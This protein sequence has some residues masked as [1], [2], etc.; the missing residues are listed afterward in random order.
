MMVYELLT[1][2]TYLSGNDAMEL[3][4]QLLFSEIEAPSKRTK[5]LPAAFDAWF[6]KAC[7]RDPSKR[8][9]TTSAQ[10]TALTVALGI[11]APPASA[12][13]ALADAI[14][15]ITPPTTVSYGFTTSP[16]RPASPEQ[17]NAALASTQPAPSAKEPSDQPRSALEPRRAYASAPDTIPEGQLTPNA[18]ATPASRHPGI[19]DAAKPPVQRAIVAVA[20][21]TLLTLTTG[22]L[23]FRACSSAGRPASAPVDRPPK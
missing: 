21:A 3:I 17:L 18:G 11:P 20:I 12:P 9:A 16:P 8:W 10:L 22:V 14:N 2:Q 15:K 23:Y 7:D 5:Q 13:T 1:G 19:A 6:L 4:T